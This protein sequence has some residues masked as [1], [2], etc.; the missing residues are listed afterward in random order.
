MNFFFFSGYNITFAVLKIEKV[1]QYGKFLGKDFLS[2][3]FFFFFENDQL[4]SII[5]GMQNFGDGLFSHN[6][7][8]MTGNPLQFFNKD[9]FIQQLLKMTNTRI[10]KF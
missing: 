5:R 9:I 6:F 8:K 3:T 2:V 10:L 4:G 1:V 7:F